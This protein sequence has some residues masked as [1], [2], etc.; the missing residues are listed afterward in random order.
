[1]LSI[2]LVLHFT[3]D[4]IQAF[5][6]ATPLS[7]HEVIVCFQLILVLFHFKSIPISYLYGLSHP[8]VAAFFVKF[9]AFSNVTDNS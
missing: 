1:M 8:S 3:L 7:T 6:G 5:E 4:F 9:Q 2:E